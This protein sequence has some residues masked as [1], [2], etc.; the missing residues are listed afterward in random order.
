MPFK[1]LPS[2]KRKRK[3]RWPSFV[4]L[5]ASS[6]SASKIARRI[7]KT[8]SKAEVALRKELWRRGARYRKN[9]RGLIGVPDLVF[10][11]PRVVVFCDGDFWHGRGWDERKRRLQSGAN[12]SYWVSKIER[13][14]ARDRRVSQE[15]TA[16][17]WTVVR[18]WERDVLVDVERAAKSVLTLLAARDGANR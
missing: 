11:A 1:G 6:P 13:N 14:R 17:G 8:D 4:G 12:A 16:N 15:L 3:R 18:L 5:K 10:A 2:K 7:R 9:V